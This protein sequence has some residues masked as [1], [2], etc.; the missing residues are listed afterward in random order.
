MPSMLSTL[1]KTRAGRYGRAVVSRLSNALLDRHINLF[2][3]GNT[4]CGATIAPFTGT[5]TLSS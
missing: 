4:G 1:G 5:K 3:K 2:A